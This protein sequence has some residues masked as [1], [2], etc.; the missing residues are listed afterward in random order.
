M[1][2]SSVRRAMSNRSN[3]EH[4]SF[5]GLRGLEVANTSLD[6]PEVNNSVN[7]IR[8]GSGDSSDSRKFSYLRSKSVASGLPRL[9]DDS[10]NSSLHDGTY[11]TKSLLRKKK[12]DSSGAGGRGISRFFKQM[13]SSM[14]LGKEKKKRNKSGDQET[15][16]KRAT[17]PSHS[18]VSNLRHQS[19]SCLT[20]R[21][22]KQIQH[23]STPRLSKL[24]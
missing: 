12:G 18:S 4:V 7:E 11:A 22:L 10:Q 21:K 8:E 3:P 20:P 19:Q 1:G 5:T 17:L 2:S 6:N 14:N 13:K 9:G 23:H 16:S 15:D 24:E